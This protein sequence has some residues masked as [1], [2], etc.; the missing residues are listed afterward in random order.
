MW[1]RRE[2]AD[3]LGIAHPIIQAPMAGLATPDLVVA[4]ANAGGLGSLGCA[5]QPVDLIREQVRA[6]RAGT[7]RPFNLN[8]LLP[9]DTPS[10]PGAVER[11]RARLTPYYDEPSLGEVP[12]VAADFPLFDEQRL[13][14]ILELRPPVVSFHFGLPFRPAISACRMRP[15]FGPSR[16]SAPAS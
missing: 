8:F 9:S 2:L 16:P 3:L 10:E 7:D 12:Q 14:L 6:V 4:V 1:P 13:E 5:G 15:H 11:M